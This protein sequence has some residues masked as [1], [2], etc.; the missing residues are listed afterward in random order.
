MPIQDQKLCESCQQ[1]PATH[2]ICCAN[3]GEMQNLCEKCFRQSS[4]PELLASS[5]F[6]REVVR[7][8]TCK[9]CGD[10]SVA[11]C[12]TSNPFTGDH[13]DLWCEACR[14]DLVVF[15]SSPENE[16][17]DFPFDD[18]LAQDRVAHQMAER[19]RRQVE[20]MRQRVL[21]RKLKENS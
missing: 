17:P 14:Q 5:D 20:F 10:P 15:G 11:G 4:S 2:H 6:F 8:G 3:T 12:D 19:E 1:H 16:I 21:E 13:L 18:E 7:K 9:Y